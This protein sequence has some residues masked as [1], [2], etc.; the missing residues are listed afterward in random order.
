MAID[1]EAFY[2]GVQREF[3][4]NALGVRRIH[5]Q[6]QPAREG[7]DAI[8]DAWEALY[9]NESIAC[10]AYIFATA[11]HE[12]GTTMQPLRE[13]F[14]TS[15]EQ[16]VRRLS[17]RRAYARRGP[18]GQAYYG[19]G[20][21]QLTHARNYRALGRCL[22]VGDDLYNNPDS[23]M[24]KEV[25]AKVICVGMMTGQFGARVTRY[26]SDTNR[27]WINARRSVNVLDCAELI[28]GYADKFYAILAGITLELPDVVVAPAPLDPST[29]EQMQPA[30]NVQPR[31]P[32]AQ[33]RTIWG[34]IV[35]FITGIYAMVRELLRNGIS[36]VMDIHNRLQAMLGFNPLWIVA[37]IFILAIAFII[38]ARID[39]R[40][41][42][43]H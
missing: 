1:R 42:K 36:W 35:A 14:A 27:D 8:F 15:D 21:V 39:D 33:S 11:W 9:P 23:V 41:K 30:P 37:A 2:A 13:S 38:Y 12:T 4:A 24:H 31:P 28:A 5:G 10:L 25:A 18:N 20:Y 7:F 19:R 29:V 26:V 6:T 3:G 43:K 32:L 16:A 40:V 22:S 17:E 34:A